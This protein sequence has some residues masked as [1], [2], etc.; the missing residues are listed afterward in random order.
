MLVIV[1]TPFKG[2]NKRE[3]LRNIEFA[4][5][6]MKDC[7]LR[8]EAPYMSHILYTQDNVLDDNVPEEREMGIEAGL[9]WGKMADKTIVY[10]DLG[11][12][13]GM[14]IGIKR[15]EDEGRPIE[16]RTLYSKV[17]TKFLGVY[18]TCNVCGK[19]TLQDNL[20][21]I[22]VCKTCLEKFHES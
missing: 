19:Q 1:E 4:Q 16:Y 22:L 18:P 17:R 21:H 20:N 6:C 8:S 12:S 7:L 15:A 10:T 9:A 13:G 11:I 2:K 5:K 3:E 14:I